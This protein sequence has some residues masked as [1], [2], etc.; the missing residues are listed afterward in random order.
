M[1]K[2][3]PWLSKLLSVDIGFVVPVQRDHLLPGTTEQE[4]SAGHG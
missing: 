1:F 4:R 2:T 3:A